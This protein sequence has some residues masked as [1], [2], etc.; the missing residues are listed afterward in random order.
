LSGCQVL[1][2]LLDLGID[3]V[4]ELCADDFIGDVYIGSDIGLLNGN[5][6]SEVL[7]VSASNGTEVSGRP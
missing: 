2:I 1:F 5:A 4:L 6:S 7:F 3:V